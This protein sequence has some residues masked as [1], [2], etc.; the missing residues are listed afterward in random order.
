MDF[1]ENDSFLDFNTHIMAS[2]MAF[3]Q[4]DEAPGQF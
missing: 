3:W 1:M 4:N 2:A